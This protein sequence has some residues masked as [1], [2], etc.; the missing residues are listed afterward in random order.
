LLNEKVQLDFFQK[1]TRELAAAC[2]GRPARSRV[3]LI[4]FHRKTHAIA[5]LKRPNGPPSPV[6]D[7]DANK[8][9]PSKAYIQMIQL[10]ARVSGKLAKSV[11]SQF[12]SK[13]KKTL[14][15][16]VFAQELQRVFFGGAC[17]YSCTGA[18]WYQHLDA[19]HSTN[20]ASFT[21]IHTDE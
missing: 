6:G 10:Q 18:S 3:P 21:E 15:I 8:A 12:A 20:A 11:F 7:V 19:P 5:L 9:D 14:N 4:F 1:E 13:K 16:W 17:D 2:H